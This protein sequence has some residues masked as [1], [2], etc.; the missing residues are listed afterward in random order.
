MGEEL[1][2]AIVRDLAGVAEDQAERVACKTLNLLT[3]RISAGEVEDFAPRLPTQLRQCLEYRR[4]PPEKYHFT[5]FLLRLQ[6]RLGVDE[7]TA[8]QA[9]K[10]VFAALWLTIGPEEFEDVRAQLPL[11]FYELIDDAI[12]LVTPPIRPPMPADEFIRRV[13]ERAGIDPDQARRA[14]EAT[15]E[16]LAIR[17]TAGEIDDIKPLLAPELR[18]ALERGIA[19]SGPQAVT[20][21]L[22][23]L[24]AKIARLEGTTNEQAEDHARAVLAVLREAIGEKEF[25]D[26][27]AQ[28]PEEY[29]RILLRRPRATALR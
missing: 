15:F 3:Q 18:P 19:E 24:L 5:D 7:A 23:A 26:I 20:M 13:A 4:D 14:T 6:E 10:A 21:A 22:D 9:A 16:V 8:A 17:I 2:T 29:T 11:D 1:F 28:F 12:A 27:V 25:R